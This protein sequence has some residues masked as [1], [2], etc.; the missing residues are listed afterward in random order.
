MCSNDVCGIYRA[1][2]EVWNYDGSGTAESPVCPTN[3]YFPTAAGQK[4]HDE[5]FDRLQGSI[6]D[7]RARRVHIQTTLTPFVFDNITGSEE[8]GGVGGTIIYGNND[9]EEQMKDIKTAINEISSGYVTYATNDGTVVTFS[10]INEAK[11]K[12]NS[13]RASCLCDS[14]CAPNTI[15]ACHVNCTCNTYSDKRLKEDVVYL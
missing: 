5:N 13:L 10:S 12:I 2:N 6:N 9:T 15:C 11:N 4:I 3:V 1:P 8:T 14:H 7:E